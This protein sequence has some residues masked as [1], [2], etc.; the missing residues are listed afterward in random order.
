ME[1]IR[2]STFRLLA[3]RG[4]ANVS[5]RDIA[6]EAGVALSQIAYYYHSK[7]ALISEVVNDAVERG[8]CGFAEMC[9]RDRCH[10][11]AG[12]G[13][14]NAAVFKRLT[15]RVGNELGEFR[16]LVEKEH[17]VVRQRY[18]ARHGIGTAAIP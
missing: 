15:Q 16:Q 8:I 5:M 12:T 11:P 10:A 3:G 1:N 2:T 6:A 13:D 18:L 9:I 7:E 17:A 4:Y 14:G